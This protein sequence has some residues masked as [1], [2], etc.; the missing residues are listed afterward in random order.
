VC[1]A[2]SYLPYPLN[3]GYSPVK[4]PDCLPTYKGRTVVKK[5][6]A[7]KISGLVRLQSVTHVGCSP[8]LCCWNLV[9]VCVCERERERERKERGVLLLFTN[10]S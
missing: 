4:P 3:V 5:R 9:C 1:L 6:T 7:R 2:D 8:G 10:V